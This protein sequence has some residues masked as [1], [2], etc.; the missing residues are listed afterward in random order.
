MTLEIIKPIGQFALK[1]LV[2]SLLVFGSVYLLQQAVDTQFLDSMF[3]PLCIL[4]YIVTLFA[5]GISYLGIHSNPEIGVYAILGG[6]MIKMLVSL[7]IFIVFLYGFEVENKVL[8]GLNFF[9][10]YLSMSCFEVMIL[11]RNLRRKIK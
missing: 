10:I 8:L 2:G 7:G 9:C 11:L 5:Y 1:L 6:T 3:V 4:L